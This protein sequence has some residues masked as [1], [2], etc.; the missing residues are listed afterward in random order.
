MFFT[1][2]WVLV[3]ATTLSRNICISS[4]GLWL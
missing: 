1:S 3:K 2:K 4:T